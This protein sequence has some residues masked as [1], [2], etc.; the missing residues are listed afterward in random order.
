MLEIKIINMKRMDDHGNLKA[1][2]DIVV[3]NCLTIRGLRI[4][5]DP[6]GDWIGYPHKT[7]QNNGQTKYSP[8]VEVAEGLKKQIRELILKEY[9]NN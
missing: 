5:S 9:E 3:N 8:I 2:V 7:Y 6:K 4:M 1:F